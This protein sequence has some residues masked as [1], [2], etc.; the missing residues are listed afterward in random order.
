MKRAHLAKIGVLI[1]FSKL[2]LFM[3]LCSRS[4]AKKALS[5]SLI[6]FL[7]SLVIGMLASS[8]RLTLASQLDLLCNDC[9]LCVLLYD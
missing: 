1:L 6:H 7:Y 5:L 8:A 3:P 4:S 2:T 9:V